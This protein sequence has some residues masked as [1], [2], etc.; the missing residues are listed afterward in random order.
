MQPEA[1]TRDVVR[2]ALEA[3]RAA[4]QLRSSP[5]IALNALGGRLRAEQLADTHDARVGLLPRWLEGLVLGQLAGLRGTSIELLEELRDTEQL[6]EQL[7]A[8]FEAQNT[9]RE[10]W[11][12]LHF[13]FFSGSSL[14]VLQLADILGVVDKTLRRRINKGYLALA[15]VLRDLELQANVATTH[16]HHLPQELTPFVGREAEIAAIRALMAEHRLVTLTGLGGIGKSRLAVRIARDLATD[17]EDGAWFVEMVGLDDR[18]L[19]P[20]IVAASLGLRELP[21]RLLADILTDH[22]VDQQTLIVLDNCE[23]VADA[24]SELL[25]R[26]LPACAG[27]QVLATSRVALNVDGQAVYAVPPMA[28]PSE[29]E[30][31]A[32]HAALH[33]DAVRLFGRR[34]IS[35]LPGQRVDAE[36]GVQLARLCVQLDGIPL[37]I[38]LAAAK[39]RFLTLDQLEERLGDRFSLLQD[40]R[41]ASRPGHETMRAVMDLSYELLREP[42]RM[43][44]RRLAVFRGGWS[45]EAAE[46]VCL[47]EGIRGSDVLELLAQLDA[48]SL[49]TVAHTEGAPRY[50]MLETV[51]QYAREQLINASEWEAVRRAHLA[52]FTGVAES[53]AATCLGPERDQRLRQMERDDDNLR[54][55]IEESMAS[56]I[57]W[58]AARLVASLTPYWMHNGH[59]SEGRRILETLLENPPEGSDEAIMAELHCGAGTMATL[60][61]DFE[62]AHYSLAKSLARFGENGDA[63]GMAR[64]NNGLFTVEMRLGNPSEAKSHGEASLMLYREVGDLAGTATMHRNLAIWEQLFG[65]YAAARRHNEESLAICR[66]IDDRRGIA[67]SLKGNAILNGLQGN[68]DEAR[69]ALEECLALEPQSGRSQE[70]AHLLSQLAIANLELGDY[71]GAR[72]LSEESYRLSLELGDK[73]GQGV[74]LLYRGCLADREGDHILARSQLEQS[75]DLFVQIGEHWGMACSALHLGNLARSEGDLAEARLLLEESLG[76]SRQGASKYDIA[77]ALQGLGELHRQLGDYEAARTCFHESLELCHEIGQRSGTL[78]LLLDSLGGIAAEENNGHRAARLTSAA[79][80]ARSDCLREIHP[81]DQQRRVEIRHLVRAQLTPSEHHRADAEG[82]ALR[83]DEAV[84]YARGEVVWEELSEAVSERIQ[85]KKLA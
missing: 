43:L 31:E 45:L 61:G 7:V 23:Q 66:S 32:S 71:Q 5:L 20:D 17:F 48:K 4:R 36:T 47:G 38:E 40:G 25:H 85:S 69:Q 28:L 75:R 83:L 41:N 35:A 73:R 58:E 1:I 77:A 16:G 30:P 12:I 70:I 72:K 78:D 21:G 84:A 19:V 80:Q 82:A 62:I 27:V 18:R 14:S 64:S 15:D 37:A 44:L 6:L 65:D 81:R 74:A 54:A 8:D 51:R 63:R 10:S 68:F 34:A 49:I 26:L 67:G 53:V 3:I 79:D 2:E 29:H 39:T 22:L 13:R 24:A 11:G 76:L 50:G 59:L 46:A 33:Y 42:E 60:Q 55:A 52:Y 57:P 56:E 9:H